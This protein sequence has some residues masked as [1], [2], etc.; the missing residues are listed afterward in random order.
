MFRFRLLVLTACI[1][2]CCS[3]GGGAQEPDVK[4]ILRK[5]I[6]AHL[7]E[8]Y[9]VEFDLTVALAESRSL[10]QIRGEHLIRQDGKVTLG[11]YGSV[12]VAGLTVE[13]SATA[14]ALPWGIVALPFSIL[15]PVPLSRW[16]MS[17]ASRC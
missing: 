3:L 1:T 9:K 12:F 14:K 8:S 17:L 13:A 5:A 10:Q 7:K 6:T 16:S 4:D 11:V 15:P 2:A